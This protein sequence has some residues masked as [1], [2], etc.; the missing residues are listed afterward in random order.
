MTLVQL[1]VERK[2]ILNGRGSFMNGS[3][4]ESIHSPLAKLEH[5]LEVLLDS[6]LLRSTK[7]RVT[8]KVTVLL[9]SCPLNY[10]QSLHLKLNLLMIIC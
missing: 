7:V 5:K 6:C 2:V 1:I 4:S 10:T 8:R 3:S 9:K